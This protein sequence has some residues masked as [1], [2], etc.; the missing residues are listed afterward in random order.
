L[1]EIEGYLDTQA[2]VTRAVKNA[3]LVIL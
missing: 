1:D 2:M 3:R